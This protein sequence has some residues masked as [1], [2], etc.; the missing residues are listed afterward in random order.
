MLMTVLLVTIIQSGCSDDLDTGLE[1]GE[2]AGFITIRLR[3]SKIATRAADNTRNEDLIKSAVICLYPNGTEAA[4]TPSYVEYVKDIDKNELAEVKIKL[5]KSLATTL[6]GTGNGSCTAYVIAN[7]PDAEASKINVDTQL[8]SLEQIVVNPDFASMKEQSS[9]VMDGTATVNRSNANTSQDQA[10]GSVNLR[11]SASKISFSVKIS[12]K[13]VDDSGA[14]WTPAPDNISVLITNGVTRSQ[15]NSSD[16]TPQSQDYYKTTTAADNDHRQRTFSKV[17]GAD[18]PYQLNSPFYTFPNKWDP[19]DVET[20]MTYMTLTVPWK[21]QGE[22][23]YRTCYYMVPVVKGNELGRN[24]NYAV[25]LNVDVLGS[26]TPDVPLPLDDLSY[27]AV[28]WGSVKMDVDLNESRYLVVD[29]NNYTMDNEEYISIPVYTS[30][31]T[32]ITDIKMK[33]RRYNTNTDGSEYVVTVPKSIID[34]SND[35]FKENNNDT[36][37]LC[38]YDFLNIDDIHKQASIDFTHKLDIW[39]PYDSRGAKINQSSLPYAVNSQSISYYSPSNPLEKAYS[40]YTIEITI[41]HEDIYKVGGTSFKELIT[42]EQYPQ[43]YIEADQNWAGGTITGNKISGSDYIFSQTKKINSEDYSEFGNVYINNNSNTSQTWGKPSTLSGN[44]SNPNMYIIT[45]TQLDENTKYIIGDPRVDNPFDLEYNNFV[46]VKD[47]D[48][49][50]RALENYYPADINKDKYI[51]P[52]FRVASS[53]GKSG[54]MSKEDAIR[55][56][57]SFQEKDC[58]A[59]RWRLPT[60]SELEYITKLSDSEKIP[61]L[62][63]LYDD[64]SSSHNGYWTAQGRVVQKPSITGGVL[65]IAS[66]QSSASVRCVYDEWYWT[67]KVKQQS[68]IIITDSYGR[69]EAEYQFNV[70]YYPFT[71]GD[72]TR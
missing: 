14:E 44:N 17:E 48:G 4:V 29:R 22:E 33:Y 25:K 1:S 3:N 34:K 19:N 32:I 12:D 52:K 45:T 26:F 63:N 55:R 11:R 57:A 39:E 5:S 21:K 35:R 43:M 15:V 42:I 68:N 70:P 31:K 23:R 38:V 69:Y 2:N 72:K 60:R 7:L 13:Y 53:W 49:T 28:E 64:D 46:K 16:Y 36:T 6:F 10:S 40:R 9:F 37:R 71:W 50:T 66:D 51:A 62:F 27:Y 47:M 24:I 59:G 58:P 20:P 18:Y 41:Q 30:H 67:D 8:S 54:K 56:C 65:K 61:M